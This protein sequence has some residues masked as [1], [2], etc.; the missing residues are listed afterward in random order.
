M[1]KDIIRKRIRTIRRELDKKKIRFLLITGPANVTYM[2]GFLGDDSWA[3]IAGGRVYLLTDSR[4]TE[5]A[6]K[7]C[8]S[9]KIIDRAGPMADAVAGLVKKLKS[10]RTVAVEDSVSMADFEQLKKAVKARFRTV[11]GIVETVRSIKDESEISTIRSA[12]AISTKALAQTLP[13]IKPGVTES[14]LAG[15]LDFQIRKLGAR[16]SF[17]TIVA[18]GPNG[19]RPHHQPGSRKLRK[20]DTVLI[21]FGAKYKGYCSDITRCFMC[22]EGILPLSP[23]AGKPVLSVVEGMPAGRKAW[24][25]HPGL[26]L[27]A[28]AGRP[29]HT[30]S[31]QIVFYKKVYDVVEQAQAA[32]IKMIKPGVK[33]TQVD[34]AAREAIDKSGLPVDSHGTGHGF[35]LEIHE[36]PFLKPD[37]KGKLKA[38][39][40]IT[41]EPGIYMPGK[42]GV[43]IEDDILVTETGYKILTHRCPHSPLLS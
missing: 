17:E 28:R 5:Q 9:C 41:I 15:M 24:R 23:A 14:E 8:P 7:E 1:D 43:R 27:D 11:A 40:V 36:S 6:Q 10:V 31:P 25:G 19:S 29:R 38:G 26:V 3:A 2:T 33:I 16:N 35:G 20:K 22:G 18:F 37:G 30:A 4:Y 21:D 42:L 34:A 13:Y 12:V 39:Q 32:A